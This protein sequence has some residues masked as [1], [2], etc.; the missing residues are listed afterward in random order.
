MYNNSSTNFRFKS[1]L[2]SSPVEN[3]SQ[4]I[5]TYKGDSHLHPSGGSVP[6]HSQYPAVGWQQEGG[7]QN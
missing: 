3:T 1:N 5:N 4:S 6:G 2:N 7:E